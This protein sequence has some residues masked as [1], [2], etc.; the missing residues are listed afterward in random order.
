MLN[1]FKI[2]LSPE[3]AAVSIK[4]GRFLHQSDHGNHGAGTALSGQGGA[5]STV[6]VDPS[7][8]TPPGRSREGRYTGGQ[9]Q[10]STPT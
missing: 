2:L 9:G 5:V 1:P 8:Y 4:V 7:L 3:F 10:I 6:H